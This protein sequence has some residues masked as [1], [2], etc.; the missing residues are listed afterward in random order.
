MVQT[1]AGEVD[2]LTL[3]AIIRLR[4]AFTI[5]SVGDWIYRF[6]VPML[7]LQLTGS[8]LATAAAYVV[9]F[10]PYVVIG[11]FAGLVADRFPRL[12]VMILCDSASAV[13]AALLALLARADHPPIAAL[14][15]VALLLAC[16][17]PFYFPAMQGLTVEGV[18]EGRRAGFNAWTQ[19]TD[20]L[21]SFS[22]PLFGT[23]VVAAVGI[24]TATSINAATFVASAA[25][26]ASIVPGA[27]RRARPPAVSSGVFRGLAVGLRTIGYS[28]AVL[29]GTAL[30]TGANFA[31]ALIQGNL[32]YILL[33]SEGQST[34]T[35]GMVFSAQGAGAVV[36]GVLAPRLM[37]RTS[38]GVVI[39][40]GMALS[41]LGMAIPAVLPVWGAILAGAGV[42]G[43]AF[44]LVVVCWYTS[45]QR[46]IP[47]EL[48]GRFV[49]MGRAIAYATLPVGAVLGAVLLDALGSV[50]ALFLVAV[51][52]QLLIAIGTVRSPVARIAGVDS[53]KGTA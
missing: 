47:V 19:V 8:P 21:L 44:A 32:V 31:T 35:L 49:A 27:T 42:N 26:L 15:A 25:L 33:H 16:I 6:A 41:L 13:V 12:K 53:G 34:L 22:G 11:P 2:R 10:V 20:G 3:A 24:G 23:A 4:A 51:A 48:I 30:M 45:L 14:Y 39:S 5:S 43:A 36:A 7:V 1:P 50:R 9:E 18:P 46:I 28:P 37:K 52:I 38:A 29:W 17:R 40:A